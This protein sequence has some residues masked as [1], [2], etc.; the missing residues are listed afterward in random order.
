[1]SSSLPASPTKASAAS[2]ITPFD[3]K[4]PEKDTFT[5]SSRVQEAEAAPG[6]QQGGI[7]SGAGV[8][9]ASFHGSEFL[10]KNKEAEE[11]AKAAQK[12]EERGKAAHE[13]ARRDEEAARRAAAE[14]NATRLLDFFNAWC[15]EEEAD[16]CEQVQEGQGGAVLWRGLGVDT[17]AAFVVQAYARRKVMRLGYLG[18]LARL[19][20]FSA[21]VKPRGDMSFSISK[22]WHGRP[23]QS[24]ATSPRSSDNT[25]QHTAGSHFT[26]DTA[27]LLTTHLSGGCAHVS[28]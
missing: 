21:C 10:A 11:G 25:W 9:A 19:K 12:A 7:R 24:G 3:H 27:L 20:R 6:E 8:K 15:K 18:Q 5:A 14:A 23:F 2:I 26:T 4:R 13:A 28:A 16:E 17:L 22:S 1:M